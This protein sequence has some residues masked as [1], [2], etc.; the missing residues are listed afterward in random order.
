MSG[1]SAMPKSD[2]TDAMVPKIGIFEKMTKKCQMA[3]F[4]L[5]N[6]FFSL[7]AN[8]TF[9]KKFANLQIVKTGIGVV[10]LDSWV[11]SKNLEK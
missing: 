6:P 2:L 11:H 7:R 8:R 10:H 1:G 3:D 4:S 9:G 5:S